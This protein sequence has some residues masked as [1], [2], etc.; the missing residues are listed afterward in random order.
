MVQK[1]EIELRTWPKSGTKIWERM[2]FVA[3][4]MAGQEEV[5][6]MVCPSQHMHSKAEML[7]LMY[8]VH[9]GHSPRIRGQARSLVSCLAL[10]F[11]SAAEE[12]EKARQTQEG[13]PYPSTYSLSLPIKKVY[14]YFCI[15][16]SLLKRAT[17][18]DDCDHVALLTVKTRIA[19]ETVVVQSSFPS[20]R[21]AIDMT[22]P[23]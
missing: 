12:G 14:M 22:T 11:R 23:G 2:V 18:L 16:V 21:K 7:K 19:P 4:T 3:M 6:V 5:L 17:S 8:G 20:A 1:E 13:N 9:I 10:G 15:F